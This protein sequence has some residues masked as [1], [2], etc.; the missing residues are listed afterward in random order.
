MKCRSTQS[1]TTTKTAVRRST[2]G[3][4]NGS[5]AKRM[6]QNSEEVPFEVEKD[7]ALLVFHNRELPDHALDVEGLTRSRIESAEEQ[8]TARKPTDATSLDQFREEM[9]DA[10]RRSLAMSAPESTHPNPIEGSGFTAQPFVI[11]ANNPVPSLF[12]TPKKG[13]KNGS[14]T[15]IVH[16][17]GAMNLID[18]E[19]S[20]PTR[21]V[22]DLL[23]AKGAV[24]GVDPFLTGAHSSA[25]GKVIRDTSDRYFTTYN[26]T[27]AA[28]RVQDI[29]SALTYLQS[30][31][32]LSTLNLIGL[33]EAGLWCLLAAGF[34][35]VDRT[36]IDANGF[37]SDNDEAY[38]Q[39]FPIPSIRRVGDFRTAG[40]LVAP[41]HLLIHNTRSIFQTDWIAE[42]YQA[43]DAA[44]RLRIETEV[45]S[46]ED[47]AAWLV[48]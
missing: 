4:A 32:G 48:K 1:I 7:E 30:Q 26:R 43:V 6:P 45:V 37:D 29:L 28:L 27:D 18:S 9:G 42:V 11:G 5:W 34:A 12:L 47:I 23:A 21:L 36:V 20:E 31:V 19:T 39:D 13:K 2:R 10:L 44:E 24:L 16:P 25:D 17:Q 3:S 14:V 41:R 46:E 22:A 38:L 35:D 40:T 33:G 15:L 8:L